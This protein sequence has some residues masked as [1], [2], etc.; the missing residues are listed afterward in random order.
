MLNL[1]LDNHKGLSFSYNYLNLPSYISN[2]GGSDI[3]LTYTADGEK[4]TKVSSAGTRSYVSG[5]EYLGA[6]LEA[7]YHGEG[8]CTPNGA[9]AFHYE[10]TIKD[11][12][13]NARVNFRANGAAVTY[14]EDMHYYPFGML[15]EG[16]GTN[17]PANDYTY[18]G[19]E[20]NEDLGLNLSDYGARWYDAALG[21]WWSVDP[22][23]D[24]TPNLSAYNY[25]GNTPLILIDPTGME[26]E[27]YDFAL[28]NSSENL[29]A[30]H[31]MILKLA[32]V[33][34]GNQ[35][36]KN[37]RD[38][39]QEKNSAWVVSRQWSGQDYEGYSNFVD[40]EI[41]SMQT[42]REEF[43]CADLATTL[44]IRYSASQG[45]EVEF[46]ATDGKKINSSSSS[47]KTPSEFEKLIM[48]TTNAKS[49]MNDMQKAVDGPAPGYMTNDGFHV[50][51]V[52]S[53]EPNTVYDSNGATPT[54]S[55][56]LGGR[57]PRNSSVS[58]GSVFK[59]WNVIAESAKAKYYENK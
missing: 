45:L 49:I 9:A 34:Y 27:A 35:I 16:M 19:K 24:G 28:K 17:S 26:S 2:T 15:M 13:G 41:Q 1:T 59:R 29:Q 40:S 33:N 39:K 36:I 8:R 5:I 42:N 31:E 57:V 3:T 51:I 18:N 44:L 10:Y 43:D 25:V 50:N 11:H 38:K 53:P 54:T 56:T 14:L 32:D 20:L 58:N 47:A 22:M 4:L 52:T 23:G 55:G 37:N 12:L 46:T 30:K 7:I 21:R 6:N 48:R